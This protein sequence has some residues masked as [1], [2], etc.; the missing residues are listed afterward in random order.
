MQKNN[1]PKKG[2]KTNT[3]KS[4]DKLSDSKNKNDRHPD[5]A[6][7]QHGKGGSGRKS[8]KET[9]NQDANRQ[10]FGEDE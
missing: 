3:G 7:E 10:G 2:S 1:P 8:N 6:E 4:S 9:E 5:S